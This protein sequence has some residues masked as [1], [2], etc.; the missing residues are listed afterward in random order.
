MMVV[1][2]R[3]VTDELHDEVEDVL[4]MMTMVLSSM[5]RESMSMVLRMMRVGV[6]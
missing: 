5:M 3:A 4:M 6:V 2:R 1:R